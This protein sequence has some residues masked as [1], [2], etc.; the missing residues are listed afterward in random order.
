MDNIKMLTFL[1]CTKLYRTKY[2]INCTLRNGNYCTINA[3]PR[4]LGVLIVPCG[5]E[6]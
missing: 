2:S 1:F 4:Y 5:M 6:T 3:Y